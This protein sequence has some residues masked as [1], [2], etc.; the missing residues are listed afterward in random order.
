MELREF[1]EEQMTE[2]YNRYMVA[3]FPQDELKPLGRILDMIKTGLCCA[4]GLYDDEKDGGGLRGYATFIVPDGLRY[5]LLDY[6]AV[7]KEYRGT[8]VGHAFFHLVG[9]T[10]T[11]RYPALRGFFIESEAVAYAADERERQIREKRIS[12]YIQNKCLDTVLGSKL[13]CVIYSILLYDFCSETGDVASTEGMALTGDVA[14][15]EGMTPT[16]GMA[17]I[18]DLDAIYRA[19]FPERHYKQNVD[20]WEDR[21]KH[22]SRQENPVRSSEDFASEPFT[23]AGISRTADRQKP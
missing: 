12:F 19:M 14:S 8:G 5:G 2:I 6:L 16:E 15:T 13:F 23:P 22:G 20:L 7:L 10:L 9:D 4:Y 18:D 3:D 1:S 11:A 17:S 21:R